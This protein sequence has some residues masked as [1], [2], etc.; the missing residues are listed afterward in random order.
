MPLGNN[1]NIAQMTSRTHKTGIFTPLTPGLLHAVCCALLASLLVVGCGKT[2]QKGAKIGAGEG[3]APVCAAPT[4]PERPAAWE[5]DPIRLTSISSDGTSLTLKVRLPEGVNP[6]DGSEPSGFNLTLPLGGKASARIV[7]CAVGGQAL[8]GLFPQ[9]EGAIRLREVGVARNWPIWHLDLLR[10]FWESIRAQAAGRKGPIDVT[11]AIAVQPAEAARPRQAVRQDNPMRRLAEKLVVN[12]GDLG[13]W[14]TAPKQASGSTD[15]RPLAKDGKV[16]LKTEIETNGLYRIEPEAL[17]AA[18][19]IS[20]P[21]D[22]ER[23]R[24]FSMGKPVQVTVASPN[25]PAGIYFYG[26]GSKSAYSKK[27]VYWMTLSPATPAARWA[28]STAMTTASLD[29]VQMVARLNRDRERL[30]ERNILLSITNIEWVDTPVS[31]S[32]TLDLPLALHRPIAGENE[33]IDA[34]LRFVMYGEPPVPAEWNGTV[35]ALNAGRRELAR[36]QFT[37]EIDQTWSP[38]LPADM[39]ADGTATLT[40]SV[41]KPTTATGA[42]ADSRIWFESMELAYPAKPTLIGGRFDFTPQSTTTPTLAR[43]AIKSPDPNSP[44]IAIEIG[45]EISSLPERDGLITV[46]NQ[47]GRRSEV[48]D[49]ARVPLLK[50]E[51]VAWADDALKSDAPVDYLIIMHPSLRGALDPLLALNGERGLSTK[52][53]EIGALYDLFGDGALTPEAIRR[54]LAHTTAWPGGAPSYVLLF[55][56]CTSDYLNQL[57][58]DVPNLVPS[59]SYRLDETW[60]SDAWFT[61]FSGA[62]ELADAMLGRISVNNLADAR[63]VV[64]KTVRY[65]RNR[66]LGPWR[67]RLTYVADETERSQPFREAAEEL[68]TRWTPAS[69]DG[70]CI[71]LDDMELEDNWYVPSDA[72]ARVYELERKMMKVSRAATDAILKEFNDGT[73]YLDFFG[74]GSPNIWCDERLLFGGDSPNRDSQ[75]LK[76]A[77]G[78]Y[79]FVANYTCNTG[80]I[81]YPDPPWNISISEDLMRAPDAGAIGMFLPAGPGDTPSH[82]MLARQWR[83]TMFMDNMRGFG[84][85]AT[86]SRLRLELGDGPRQM[87][88]MYVLLGD[89]ALRLQLAERWQAL[90]VGAQTVNPD[91]GDVRHVARA[92]GIAPESGQ[93]RIWVED[94]K[95][96]KLWESAPVT[97]EGGRIELP[98][99]IPA[100]LVTPAKLRVGMYGWNETQGQDFTAGALLEARR[101]WVKIESVGL[102]SASQAHAIRV[103][104]HNSDPAPS[105]N[106]MLAILNDGKQIANQQLRL[107]PGERREVELPVQ[108]ADGVALEATLAPS[109]PPDSPQAPLV[110]KF[111]FNIAGDGVTTQTMPASAA[112][113]RIVPASIKHEPEPVTEGHTI[114]VVFEVE[115]AGE[116]ASAPMRA[117][118]LDNAPEKGGKVLSMQPYLPA[119]EIPSLGAGRT[120]P[121]RLRW[122]PVFNAGVKKVWLHLSPLSGP[123]PANAVEQTA[124]HTIFARTKWNLVRLGIKQSPR[125]E[126]D[127]KLGRFQLT[128]RIGNRGQTEARGVEVTFYTG[129]EKRDDQVMGKV[130]VERVPAATNNGIGQ[131]DAVLIWALD[132][133]KYPGL[134]PA[135]INVTLDIRLLGSSQRTGG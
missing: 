115:N 112:R 89:P 96:G 87:L 70:H 5:G 58:N 56:D 34:T 95:G 80:A 79:A 37:G 121:V 51:P 123:S 72:L 55:G 19:L 76:P 120:W 119:V 12:P 93:A 71:Y 105:G 127:K 47:N 122:D 109:R 74:H 82:L 101:P 99:E 94:A 113:V 116:T 25:Q 24:V 15:P 128:A 42:R 1:Q 85:L 73:A 10:P 114:N 52:V 35:V 6:P 27:R 8:N 23:V 30:I 125:S 118:L 132:P 18:G 88:Y 110:E 48:Y 49:S 66:T 11:L 77:A 54:Y 26:E 134:S 57:H 53:V 41:V 3:L 68:R 102:K 20:G 111:A 7:G 31:D 32:K 133:K 90:D 64:D 81:D 60:A 78:R 13:R 84:E 100:N 62:D 135:Q 16:W 126:E 59:Y 92:T 75:H 65:A 61:M 28:E 39:L 67:A 108:I 44:L 2:E 83:K 131:A 14:E 45:E 46:S 22:L 106:L 4:K 63:A 98:F 21:A 69:F 29:R 33:E 104:L 36:Y 97:Y 124:S 129:P 103:N 38:K 40:L 17:Q 9:A 91:L 117:E 107:G 43:I 86:M 130:N 50:P